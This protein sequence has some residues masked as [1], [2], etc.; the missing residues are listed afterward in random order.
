MDPDDPFAADAVKGLLLNTLGI[1]D[2]EA[3]SRAERSFSITRALEITKTE[4]DLG[5]RLD[6]DVVRRC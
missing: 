6:L 2:P 5:D 1:T 4:V 3:L